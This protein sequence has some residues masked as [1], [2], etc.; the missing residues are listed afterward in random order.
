MMVELADFINDLDDDHI[1]LLVSFGFCK[2][3]ENSKY[4]IQKY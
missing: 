4:S 3:I 2:V 1:V